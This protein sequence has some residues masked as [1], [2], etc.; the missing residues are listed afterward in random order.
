MT[1]RQQNSYD[2]AMTHLSD[3]QICIVDSE[4]IKLI[5]L[6]VENFE[7]FLIS[8]D[9]ELFSIEL[10]LYVKC[11]LV[12]LY[13]DLLFFKKIKTEYIERAFELLIQIFSSDSNNEKAGSYI[14]PIVERL[15]LNFKGDI[16]LCEK[17]L[18][19]LFR[20]QPTNAHLAIKLGDF[21][22]S[23]KDFDQAF[24]FYNIA[25]SN[26][27]LPVVGLL[28]YNNMSIIECGR[29]DYKKS[30]M[31]ALK[32]IQISHND[33]NMNNN[34]ALAYTYL[35]KFSLAKRHFEIAFVN[36]ESTV[37]SDKTNL[38]SIVYMNF[39]FMY[40]KQFDYNNAIKYYDMAFEISPNVVQFN[41]KL[42]NLNYKIFEDRM[43]STNQH[44]LINGF[45]EKSTHSFNE[46]FFRSDKINI[47]LVSAD[48]KIGHVVYFFV[49]SLIDNYNKD[50][51][52]ITCYSDGD[53]TI[54]TKNIKGMSAVDVASMI[55]SDKIH[56]L[57]DLSAHTCG[58]RLDVFARKPSPIQIT[59][60]GYPF[61]TGLNEMDYRISD[62][63]CDNEEQ[64]KYYTEKLCL[65]DGCF[66]CYNPIV[67]PE[68]IKYSDRELIIGCFNR[69]NKITDSYI[70][71]CNKILSD[72]P[73]IRLVFNAKS[74]H[75][76]EI[77]DTFLSKFI[78]KTRTSFIISTGPL[79]EHLDTYNQVDITLDTFPYSGT[80]TTCESLL[81]GVPVLTIYNS[82]NSH[83]SN[84]TTS[85]L[86]NSNLSY[87]VCS[88]FDEVS[89]KIK[90][91]QLINRTNMRES[92]RQKFLSG[93]V[94]NKDFYSKTMES[95]FETLYNKHAILPKTS[96]EV[97]Q[98]FLNKEWPVNWY[99][100]QLHS[101]EL[102]CVIVEPRCHSNLARVIKN[103]ASQ[104]NNYS[105]TWY[106]SKANE[107][108][109]DDKLPSEALQ[110]IKKVVFCDDNITLDQ[111]NDLMTSSSFYDSF[112]SKRILIFQTDAGCLRNNIQ[113]FLKY[114]YIGAPWPQGHTLKTITSDLVC[115]NGGL[116][117]RNPKLMKRICERPNVLYSKTPEDYFF[118]QHLSD[119]S[120]VNSSI[121]FPKTREEASLFSSETMMN[122]ESF[123][124]H[125][126]CKF[127]PYDIMYRLLSV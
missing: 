8:E 109:L 35:N 92:T 9:I 91:I 12:S 125:A 67:I 112:K 16:E 68:I 104:L 29:A 27:Q 18:N 10:I 79:I 126:V 106:C 100:I 78:D 47:G 84:V 105:F 107:H 1:L 90:E 70:E 121:C 34:L 122:F 63:F 77:A 127:F 43:Y 111:Y 69:P 11:N 95:L 3:L 59:Y 98:E 103:F 21:Y 38:L 86:K 6:S 116:S 54:P 7:H 55:H 49:S 37:L 40:D 42:M 33:P 108:F 19:S 94:C 28:A 60:L 115:G 17:Q 101:E 80:T 114:D 99:E 74:F 75:N 123:G 20:I 44:K 81:M 119:I 32:G 52:S 15:R 64:Q 57:I 25:I 50:K 83:V 96:E 89:R 85:I 41:Y 45:L 71:L 110:K 61:T 124:F 51:F 88:D 117:L 62:K 46:E 22:I 13:H 31:Y 23:V 58:N 4:K 82:E 72:H 56:I 120:R 39:A 26:Y 73:N 5:L 97:Y 102:E 113:D 2:I 66:L 93:N 53:S 36:Y 30:A 24:K 87:C 76:K 14:I 118:S 65:I 48:L